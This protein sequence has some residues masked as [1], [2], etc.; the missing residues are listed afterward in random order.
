MRKIEQQMIEAINNQSDWRLN[1]TQVVCNE[2]KQ[3]KAEIN[4]VSV[5]L[6]ESTIAII[7]ENEVRINNCGWFSPTTKSRL[8]AILNSYC[9]TIIFQ[10]NKRWYLI[11]ENEYV[12]VI[13]NT[14]YSIARAHGTIT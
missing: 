12:E 11:K 1:N 2:D 10:R 8:N 7:T 14:T 9:N 4:Q 5:I 6:Y 3:G 13:S